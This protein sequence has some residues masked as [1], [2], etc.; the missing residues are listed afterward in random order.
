[1]RTMKGMFVASVAL[2][3][4]AACGKE[5]AP[6]AMP[7]AAAPAPVAAPVKA[8]PPSA[9][10]EARAAAPNVPKDA[11]KATSIGTGPL[12]V[13]TAQPGDSGDATWTEQVDIDGDSTAAQMNVLWDDEVNILYFYGQDDE[14]CADGG[15]ANLQVLAALYGTGNAQGAPVGSGWKLDYVDATQCGATSPVLWGVRFDST[16][17]VYAAGVASIDPAT[18]AVT[19]TAATDSMPAMPAAQQ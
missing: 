10:T 16:G 1:M 7:A 11:T 5:K 3:G 2:L 12:Q 14:V 13:N 19:I 17:N 6:E 8:S 15:V 18:G 9:T 4:L